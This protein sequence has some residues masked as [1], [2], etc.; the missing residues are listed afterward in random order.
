MKTTL[1]E[2]IVCFPG[3]PFLMERF[4]RLDAHAQGFKITMLQTD[5]RIS[6][7]HLHAGGGRTA[8]AW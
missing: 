7:V 8:V 4:W 2:D 1:Q 6:L 3:D 5:S